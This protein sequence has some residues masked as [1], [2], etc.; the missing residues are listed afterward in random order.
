MFL[1]AGMVKG[2]KACK[3][4]GSKSVYCCI[5]RKPMIQAASRTIGVTMQ[6]NNREHYRSGSMAELMD[7]R[8]APKFRGFGSYDHESENNSLFANPETYGL[9][10]TLLAL[11]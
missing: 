9:P 4:S 5:L 2:F 8:A 3:A 11:N 7:N 6:E 1:T 10:T